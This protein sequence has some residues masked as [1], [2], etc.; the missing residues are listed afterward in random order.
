MDS[1]QAL[2]SAYTEAIK[3]PPAQERDTLVGSSP[4]LEIL[5]YGV[6]RPTMRLLSLEQSDYP[7]VKY[8][9]KSDWRKSE[10]FRKDTSELETKGTGR[11]A[12]RSSKGENVMMLYIEDEN[13]SPVCGTLAS[14][15]RDLARSI[16]RGFYMRGVAPEKWGDASKEVRDEFCYEME[17]KF[18]V[19][20]YCDNHWKV[21]TLATSIYSQWYRSF[22]KKRHAAKKENEEPPTKKIR[23]GDDDVDYPQSPQHEGP[24]DGNTASTSGALMLKDPL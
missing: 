21:H 9:T 7:H 8:W 23:T 5:P 16:W 6:L 2:M 13:G 24:A 1:H 19:L 3:Q 14:E 20:R 11:G 12:S 15:I 4:S 17:S 22:D 18:G 10:N